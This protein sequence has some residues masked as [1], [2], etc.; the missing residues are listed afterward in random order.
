MYR[1]AKAGHVGCSLSAADVMTFIHF[2]CM[3]N[4]DE[5]IL[6]KGHAA[7][8]L[9]SVL[10]EKGLLTEADVDSFYQDNTYLAAH[11]P[12]GKLPGIPFAT[13]SLGHGLSLAAGLALATRLEGKDRKIFCLTSDGELNEGSIWEAA[14]FIIHQQLRQ[15]I[16][17]IDRNGLQGFGRTE[18]VMQLEPLAQKLQAWGFQVITCQGHDYEALEKAR[19]ASEAADRPVVVIA[20]TT[21]GKGWE[22]LQNQVDCHYLPMTDEDYTAILQALEAEYKEQAAG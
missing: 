19:R 2:G 14:L 13:G 1:K 17:W 3:Q 22:R 18:E 9:Y 20:Q 5:F 7:A 16:W 8:L 21:K 6:S 12:A 15:V 11:P 4:D 10:A